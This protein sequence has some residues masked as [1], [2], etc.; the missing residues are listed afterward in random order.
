MNPPCSRST[1]RCVPLHQG[2]Q[3][4]LLFLSR[5]EMNEMCS[6]C[7]DTDEWST[8]GELRLRP[9]PDPSWLGNLNHLVRC[10]MLSFFILSPDSMH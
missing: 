7:L 10:I 2:L 9:P 8:I 3:V 6:L 1:V 5:V 4:S